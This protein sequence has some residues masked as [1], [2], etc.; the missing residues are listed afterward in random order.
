MIKLRRLNNFRGIKRML[1][2]M[3]GT[4]KSITFPYHNE[5]RRRELPSYERKSGRLQM[6]LWYDTIMQFAVATCLQCELRWDWWLIEICCNTFERFSTLLYTITSLYSRC[7][8]C[9]WCLN[10][11]GFMCGFGFEEALSYCGRQSAFFLS[12]QAIVLI[13]LGIYYS[14]N[15]YFLHSIFWGFLDCRIQ[16]SDEK[17]S[18]SKNFR[19]Q[20]NF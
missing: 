7:C 15:L 20:T 12:N 14:L 19:W 3:D 9:F 11:L 16:I 4:E 10:V 6:P 13:L 17:F 5:R 8:V 2:F 18:I 1:I